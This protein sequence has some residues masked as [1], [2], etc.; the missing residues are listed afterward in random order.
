MKCSCRKAEKIS[1]LRKDEVKELVAFLKRF[2]EVA[3]L[4][5]ELVNSFRP[6]ESEDKRWK[7]VFLAIKDMVSFSE[8]PLIEIERLLDL[9]ERFFVKG[10]DKR[11]GDFLEVLVSETGPFFFNERSRRLNQCRLFKGRKKISDKEIDVAFVSRNF[12]ELHECKSN[13]IRQW[14]DP[15]TARNKRGKKLIFM[16][17]LVDVCGDERKVFP[18]CTGFE[19]KLAVRYLEKL[20][21]SYGFNNVRVVGR[22]K[23]TGGLVDRK[24]QKS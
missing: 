3:N 22:E 8:L 4:V 10:S 11:R 2:P 15:L 7:R 1:S 9:L 21:E 18:C 14:R 12:M 17:S 5:L 23:I 24:T 20:F 19:G 6:T 13:M 16:D